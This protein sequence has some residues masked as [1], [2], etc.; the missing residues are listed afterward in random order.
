MIRQRLWTILTTLILLV[1]FALVPASAQDVQDAG[2]DTTV[3]IAP[4]NG[5]AETPIQVIANGFPP[6]SGVFIGIGEPESEYEVITT[7]RSDAYGLVTTQV[8]IPSFYDTTNVNELVVV[9]GTDDTLYED[10]VSVPFTLMTDDEFRTPVVDLVPRSGVAGS[11]VTVSA[12]GY[13]PNTDVVLGIGP[14]N[15]AFDYSLRETTDANGNLVTDVAIPND[16]RA[17]RNWQI[18]VEVDENR[19]YQAFSP[20]FRVTGVEPTPIPDTQP[21]GPEFT[22]SD[23]YLIALNSS[24]GT[25]VGCNDSAIPVEV[26]YDPTIA[27]LT[28]SLEALFDMD[29]QMV[30]Q[31]GLYNALY[32][33]DLSLQRI[34]IENGVATI[35]IAGELI[36]GGACDTPRAI[37]QIEQTA[38]QFATIDEVIIYIG[39]EQYF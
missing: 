31:S 35:E 29:S 3:A 25:P 6:N 16:A 22:S 11:E 19:D 5:N 1:G 38:L 8:L 15:A 7:A 2:E 36:V 10:A 39:G 4:L 21:D 32:Q 24:T 37:A 23:I 13:P 20:T 33:S 14:Q 12:S 17:N 9:V 34:D 30:G 18:L 27:P 28:A 26:S